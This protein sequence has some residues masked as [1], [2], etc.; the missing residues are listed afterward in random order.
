MHVTGGITEL[1]FRRRTRVAGFVAAGLGCLV[2]AGCA[3]QSTTAPTGS[4]ASATYSVQLCSEAALYQTAANDVVTLDV[5]KAGADGVKQALLNLQTAT[6]NLV[7]V[8]ANENS[9]APSFRRSKR[10][11]RR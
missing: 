6:N 4:T 10:P 7:A 9:S 11:V 5:S 1:A 8:A 2:L 3:S